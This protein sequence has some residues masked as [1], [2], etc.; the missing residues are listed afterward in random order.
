MN[1]GVQIFATD[2]TMPMHR[3]APEVEQRGFESLWV[4]EKTHV[5]ISRRT[6]WPGGELPEW[7]RRTCDPFVA[8]SA[9][10]AVTSTLRIGTGVALL[11]LRDPVVAAKTVATLDWQSDGRLELGVGYGWNAEELAT[12]GVTLDEAP[13]RL[14]DYLTLMKAFWAEDAAEH[15]GPYASVE[16]S[17]SWPKPISPGGPPIHLG[18]R[19]STA[20][21]EWV[22]SFADGWLPIEGYGTIVG[23]IPR[24]RAA[25]DSHGRDPASALVSVYSSAGDQVTIEAYR[26]AGVDRVVCWL[27][28]ADEATVMSALD[29]LEQRLRPFLQD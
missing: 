23:Q 26:D 22:A 24:L 3:L 19:A 5:P 29:R 2:Q 18:S 25:F 9:A 1:V 28:P 10:A 8:L 16:P 21:F 14:A 4:P 17:W 12:H 15:H 11:A 6:T 13:T 7:Y 20:N 27:P